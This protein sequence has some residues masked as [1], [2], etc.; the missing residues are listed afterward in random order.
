M[1]NRIKFNWKIIGIDNKTKTLAVKYSLLDGSKEYNL[2]IN[3][4]S[5][6]NVSLNDYIESCAPIGYWQAETKSEPKVNLQSNLVGLSGSAN[7][8]P[9]S[10]EI[11]KQEK[12]EEIAAYRYNLEVSGIVFNGYNISTSRS[13]QSMIASAYSSLKQGLTSVID[14]KITNDT[15]IQ[16]DLG[17]MENLAKA[18]SSHVQKCFTLEKDLIE[19]VKA[20]SSV[21]EVFAIKL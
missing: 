18:V 7:I 15:F 16:L 14:F 2:N 11:A 12:L 17:L 6:S 10:L 3:S 20:C 13:S 19:K 21:S 9:V 1:S 4:P 5:S 8:R